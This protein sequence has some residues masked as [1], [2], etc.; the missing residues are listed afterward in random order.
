MDKGWI[1]QLRWRLLG[2]F[3]RYIYAHLGTPARSYTL[4]FGCWKDAQVL[5]WIV[6][7]S[8]PSFKATITPEQQEEFEKV[9]Q[10]HIQPAVNAALA[11]MP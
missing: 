11:N 4:L 5:N 1:I 3:L 10:Q 2:N 6:V 8:R 7:N 9:V